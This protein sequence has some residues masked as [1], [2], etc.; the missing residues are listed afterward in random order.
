MIEDSGGEDEAAGCQGLAHELIS[1][2]PHT[3]H[4]RESIYIQRDTVIRVAKVFNL[5]GLPLKY[6]IWRS[7]G[8]VGAS[9]RLI[10]FRS[11]LYS[12]GLLELACQVYVAFFALS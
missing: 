10:F 7:Y 4:L 9:V 2:L 8:N 12:N 6:S 3:L 11:H 1:Y 5:N